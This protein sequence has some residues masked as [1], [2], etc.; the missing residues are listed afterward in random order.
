MGRVQLTALKKVSKPCGCGEVAFCSNI[1]LRIVSLSQ[2]RSQYKISEGGAGHQG[3]WGDLKFFQILVKMVCFKAFLSVDCLF[4]CFAN[5]WL[6]IA[7]GGITSRYP[8]PW[9]APGLSSR[10]CNREASRAS[11]IEIH[12]PANTEHTNFCCSLQLWYPRIRSKKCS[13][14]F[15]YDVLCSSDRFQ[16]STSIILVKFFKFK[17]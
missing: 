13:H 3:V 6:N 1:E 5:K 17:L 11:R 4:Y 7:G 10:L 14:Y 15:V 16:S 12:W 9:H 2:W 8:P